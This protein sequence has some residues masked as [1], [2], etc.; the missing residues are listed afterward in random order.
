MED[1]GSQ[2][3]NWGDGREEVMEEPTEELLVPTRWEPR[4]KYRKCELV[5]RDRKNPMYWQPGTVL[6]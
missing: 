3:K 4:G 1:E 5:R 6:I 2:E